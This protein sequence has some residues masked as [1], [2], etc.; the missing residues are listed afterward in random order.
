[1]VKDSP[2]EN[3]KR[4]FI[5]KFDV[6]YSMW[7]P[8]WLLN[9]LEKMKDKIV[10]MRTIGQSIPHQEEQ[11][12]YLKENG[13]KIVRCSPLEKIIPGYA[14]ED[15]LIRFYK[16]PL[17]FALW[18]GD[19]LR[20]ISVAQ[21]MIKRNHSNNYSVFEEATRGLNRVLY[22]NDNEECSFWGGFLDYERLKEEYRRNRLYFYT[23]THPAPYTLNFIEAW[24]TGIPIVAIGEV[25]GNA[26]F[27]NYKTY[28]IGDLIENGV[29]GFISNNIDELHSYCERLLKE[30]QLAFKISVAGR[31]SAIKHFGKAKIKEQWKE[32]FSKLN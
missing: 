8:E 1:M 32:F 11:L 27:L 7:Y 30:S 26:S 6:I 5:E 10:I 31:S 13:V 4:E 18:K 2:K 17:E 9:N 21:A 23:G 25:Y 29:N 12:R 15:A 28:E 3:M 19:R 24:M 16:D 22:G 14:G 20:V